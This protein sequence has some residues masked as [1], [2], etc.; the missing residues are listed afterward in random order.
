MVGAGRN[1]AGTLVETGYFGSAQAALKVSEYRDR[2]E[3]TMSTRSKKVSPS[4]RK[5]GAYP[6]KD[7]LQCG[8][9]TEQEITRDPSEKAVPTDALAMRMASGI[10]HEDRVVERFLTRWGRKANQ[11]VLRFEV[12]DE[13]PASLRRIEELT[14]PTQVALHITCTG[15]R[16][17]EARDRMEAA[18]IKAMSRGV[19]VLI[20][21]RL[22]T[23]ELAGEPDLL[24]S[25]RVPG[26]PSKR[27]TYLGVDIKEHNPMSGKSAAKPWECSP[28]AKPFYDAADAADLEGTPQIKDSLQLAMYWRL[29]EH[30]GRAGARIGGII[31]KDDQVVWRSLDDG[32]YFQGASSMELWDSTYTAF[33]HTQR[34]AE[35]RLAGK[36]ADEPL[37]GP[38][39][40]AECSECAWREVC[41]EE[42]EDAGDISLLPDMTPIR[43]RVHRELGVTT[44]TQ[45]AKLH[46][47]TAQ[48]IDAGV[49]ITKVIETSRVLREPVPVSALTTSKQSAALVA[50]GIETSDQL[51]ILDSATARYS[52]TKVYKLAQ[53]IDQARVHKAQRVHRARGIS[54]VE[55]PRAAVELDVDIEDDSGGICYLIGVRE[56]IRTRGEVKSRFVPFVTWGNTSDDEAQVFAEFWTYLRSMQEKAKTGKIGSFRAYYYTEHETRYFKH[57]AKSHAGKPGVPSLDEVEAFMASDAWIDMHPII[58]RQLVWPTKDRTLKSL[59]KYVKFFWRDETPGGANSVAWY[60][61]AVTTLDPEQAEAL[62]TRI[63]EYNEDDVAATWHLREW[64][65]RFGESRKP[66]TKL[67]EVSELDRRYDP[68]PRKRGSA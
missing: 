32:L 2:R 59:A 25:E 53:A 5:V 48:L 13:S 67:P 50:S 49:E 63:L 15:E 56:T 11:H 8:Y 30:H 35:L 39:W 4:R 28:L 7:H 37:V 6:V 34:H 47:R 62:K 27:R 18:T 14:D 21:C 24:V 38:V 68:K 1:T 66:G 3:T 60:R 51:A 19:A 61:E 9:L 43:G 26:S 16:S 42:L 22:T 55:I 41:W 33:R 29:L 10:T 12:G 17:L 65:S 44:V 45:L 46:I 64:V 57:L 54:H 52:G 20:G 23:D 31:G 36:V 40:K 58:G